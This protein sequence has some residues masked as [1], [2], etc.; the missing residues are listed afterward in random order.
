MYLIEIFEMYED[1]LEEYGNPETAY[2]A[3]VIS[4]GKELVT[5]VNIARDIVE[6]A[7]Y[8]FKEEYI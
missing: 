7:L 1:Y 5:S 3:T 2:S 8:R 4:V 6:E